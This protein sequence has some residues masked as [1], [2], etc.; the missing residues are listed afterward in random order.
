MI[1]GRSLL[2]RIIFLIFQDIRII[3]RGVLL[4]LTNSLS[5]KYLIINDFVQ[6]KLRSIHGSQVLQMYLLGNPILQKV[7][8]FP[9]KSKLP[10][11][12]D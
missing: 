11:S 2:G 10:Y 9:P 6:C 1:L 8:W 12:V 7:L 4:P 3:V 5:E